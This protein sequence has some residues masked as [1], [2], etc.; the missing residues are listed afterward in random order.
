MRAFQLSE[1]IRSVSLNSLDSPLLLWEWPTPAAR[2]PRTLAAQLKAS[3]RQPTARDV[4]A[5]ADLDDPL[6]QAQVL[7]VSKAPGTSNPFGM[8][9]TVGRLETNDVVLDDESVSRFHAWFEVRAGSWSLVDAESV[10]GTKVGGKPVAAKA[11]TRLVDGTRVHFGR[12]EVIFLSS[13][14]SLFERV[15]RK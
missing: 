8:G 12:V 1:F 4:G 11:P 15:G 9:V 13:A 14:R 3:R 6:P 7:L 5:L 2:L 10:F